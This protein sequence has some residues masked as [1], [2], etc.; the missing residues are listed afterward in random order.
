MVELSTR[1]W[2]IGGNHHEK[3][4]LREFCVWVNWPSPIQQ[5]RVLIRRTLTP[6]CGL[7]NPLRQVIP[8]ISH[9][10]SYPP[11]HSHLHPL[12][13][14]F[15][16]TTQPSSQNT[17]LSHPSLSLHDN[18]MSWHR[19][20]HTPSTAPTQHCLSSLHSNDYELTTE[21]S[22]SIRRTSLHARPPWASSP[23]E[24]KGKVTLSHSHGCELTDWW[25]VSHHPGRRPSTA[26]K[27]MCDLARSRPP[28]ASPIS[29]DHGLHVHLQT[30]SITAS[31]CI[32]NLA[33]LRPASSHK[34][35]LQ[36]H[37]QSRSITASKSISKLARS[38][39]R[40]VS[41]NSLDYGLQVCTSMASKCIINLARS[42]PPSASPNCLDHGLGVNIWVYSIVIFRHTSNCSQAL[43]AASPD[44]ACVDG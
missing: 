9:I 43:P 3:L 18:I 16:S 38:R 14:S 34:H 35:G 17:K 44:I 25:R 13:L 32:S 21:S 39:P 33:P 42:G 29:L 11:Y 19:V 28:Q 6:I 22:F 2:E 37:L 8:L 40:S 30:H 31:R 41:Q 15:S 24:L 26:S 1:K 5:A 10:R 20:Q 7:P 27:Y 4:G 12:S 23:W 36:V